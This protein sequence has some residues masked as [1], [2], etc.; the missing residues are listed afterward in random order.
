M[1]KTFIKNQ[2]LGFSI[3]EMIFVIFILTIIGVAIANF[4]FNIFSL[5]KISTDNLTSQKE[6]YQAL[7]IIR[8]EI[9]SMSSSNKGDYPIIKVATST[10]TFYNDTN[11]DGRKEK[12]RYF[13]SDNNLKRGIIESAGNSDIYDSEKE[14]ITNLIRNIANDTE[15][16]FDFYDSNYNIISNPLTEKITDIRLIKINIFI[17]NNISKSSEPLYITSQASIRIL[18]DNL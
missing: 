4:Q 11:N 9:R 5:N 17:N 1:R 18:K 13:L 14:I 16:I 2:Q 7:K 8:T 15:T 10:F 12:I 6:I 3:L